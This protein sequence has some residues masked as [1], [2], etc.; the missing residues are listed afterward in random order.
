MKASYLRIDI[1]ARRNYVN[2]LSLGSNLQPSLGTSAFSKSKTPPIDYRL[3][4][5][6]NR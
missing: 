5:H 1:A 2:E 4:H 3:H 6:E